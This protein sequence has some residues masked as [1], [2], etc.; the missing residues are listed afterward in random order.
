MPLASGP[1]DRRLK[2]GGRLVRNVPGGYARAVL[3]EAQRSSP[4]NAGPGTRNNDNFAART[5]L[6]RLAAAIVEGG[7]IVHGV[8][9]RLRNI[10]SGRDFSRLRR[11]FGGR[12]FL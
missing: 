2:L 5:L 12:V 10:Q 11:G 4:T 7:W 6:P 3:G 9:G 1:I 8:V